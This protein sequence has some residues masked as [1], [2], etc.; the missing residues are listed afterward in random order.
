MAV[1]PALKFF[2]CFIFHPLFK[3]RCNYATEKKKEKKEKP[4]KRLFFNNEKKLSLMI[5]LAWFL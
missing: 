3:K 5:V 1:W 4:R 2:Y